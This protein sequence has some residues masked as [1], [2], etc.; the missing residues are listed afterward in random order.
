MTRKW[1]FAIVG[2]VFFCGSSLW[3]QP[4]TV[5]ITGNTHSRIFLLHNGKKVCLPC[6]RGVLLE[7]FDPDNTIL[8]EYGYL[9]P[10][11]FGDVT[12]QSGES[13]K[14]REDYL[15]ML[16]RMGYDYLCDLSGNCPETKVVSKQGI[17]IG[18]LKLGRGEVED[19]A[20][21]NEKMKKMGKVDSLFLV[22]APDI[23]SAELRIFL[24]GHEEVDVVLV[25]RREFLESSGWWDWQGRVLLL[26]PYPDG[27]EVEK[28][29]LQR[30]DTLRPKEVTNLSVLSVDKEDPALSSLASRECYGDEDC[31]TGVCS[32]GACRGYRDSVVLTV[33]RPKRCISC[34]ETEVY[35][36]IKGFVP[37]LN[38]KVVYSE[39]P[40]AKKWLSKVE[41]DMLPIFFLS[42]SIEKIKGF[43]NLED[44][45]I[46]VDDVYVLKPQVVG[47]SVLTNRSRIP[48]RI[49]YFVSGRLSDNAYEVLK[50]LRDLRNKGDLSG[51]KIY[52]HY[53]VSLNNGTWESLLGPVDMQEVIRQLCVRRYAPD[54]YLDYVVCRYEVGY[55]E[56][57]VCEIR[58]G[59]D[60]KA[61]ESCVRNTGEFGYLLVSSAKLTQEIGANTV[62]LMLFENQQ[63]FIPTPDAITV[64]NFNKWSE[65]KE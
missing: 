12:L 58:L 34:N 42:R 4:L 16:K 1:L 35:D 17:R 14:R 51:W 41:T 49:D 9:S 55:V 62:G 3:A 54:K 59:V 38:L 20:R 21:Y 45:L 28:V 52:L 63:I 31:A 26:C 36:W 10:G 24:S 11:S 43:E 64:E 15:K 23:S 18:F 50:R 25:P 60:K 46:R 61:I 56:D 32:G 40:E 53:L 8:V 65:G 13:E 29:T 39:T 6:R 27:I 48:Y 5:L 44:L 57:S 30:G 19:P 22:V 47:A 37:G 7:R 2:F 33:V